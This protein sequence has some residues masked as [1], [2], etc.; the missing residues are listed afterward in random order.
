MFLNKFQHVIVNNI[1]S[2]KTL[3][4]SVF[5]KLFNFSHDFLVKKIF[6]FRLFT[7]IYIC[8]TIEITSFHMLKTKPQFFTNTLQKDISLLTWKLVSFRT[9]LHG[10]SHKVRILPLWKT[11]MDQSNISRFALYKIN[12]R[13]VVWIWVKFFFVDFNLYMFKAFSKDNWNLSSIRWD[14]NTLQR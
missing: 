9:K 8:T 6:L 3:T 13:V 2:L 12:W 7:F 4:R 5:F 11:L 14:I 10:K 1:H